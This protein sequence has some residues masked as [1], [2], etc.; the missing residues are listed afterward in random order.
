MIN[1]VSE[2]RDALMIDLESDSDI[3]MLDA[4][5]EVAEYAMESAAFEYDGVNSAAFE[6]ADNNFIDKAGEFCKKVCEKVKA[7]CVAAIRTIRMI[8]PKLKQ[9]INM[10]I[11]KIYQ[12]K[13]ER[14]Q[15]KIDAINDPKNA[16]LAA[17]ANEKIKNS[18]LALLKAGLK[19]DPQAF[20]S[21]CLDKALD[22]E[23]I[24]G[25]K[26]DLEIEKDVFIDEHKE[27]GEDRAS[28]K[29]AKDYLDNA[30]KYLNSLNESTKLQSKWLD[31]MAEGGNS[32]GI[33]RA[34]ATSYNVATSAVRKYYHAAMN[35]AKKFVRVDKDG[36]VFKKSEEIGAKIGTKIGNKIN[37]DAAKYAEKHGLSY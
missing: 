13:A 7:F 9:F 5:C 36:K 25:T 16:S 31:K 11:N 12:A 28:A 23:K 20:V 27:S 35:L 19:T 30:V 15:K 3:A 22:N 4:S 8:L 18:D 34:M 24:V 1:T 2:L 29:D 6:A 21:D 17:M 10:G 32:T 26:K 33:R 14:M 37:K